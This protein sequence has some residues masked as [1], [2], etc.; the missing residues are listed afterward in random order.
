MQIK[1]TVFFDDPFWVGIFEREGQDVYELCK[2]IFGSEPKDY[3]VYDFI[4]KN[5]N[6]LKFR[7]V[8]NSEASYKSKKINPKRLQ[9]KISKDI[10]A[11][12]PSK[13]AYDA[14]NQIREQNKIERKS[15]NSAQKKAEKDEKF[16]KKQIKKK[17]KKKGH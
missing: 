7:G 6:D 9:R 1:L 12:G 2:V 4:L 11:K 13:K 3:D 10:K 15:K 17:K 14:I 5:F 8:K 16:N